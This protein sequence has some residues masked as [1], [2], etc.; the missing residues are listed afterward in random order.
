MTNKSCDTGN[1]CIHAFNITYELVMISE[2]DYA[3]AIGVKMK[4]YIQIKSALRSLVDSTW[5]GVL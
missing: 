4:L 5:G 3:F 2:Q 1:L